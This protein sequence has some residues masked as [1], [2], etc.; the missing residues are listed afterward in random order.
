MGIWVLQLLDRL[1]EGTMRALGAASNLAFLIGPMLLAVMLVRRW[2]GDPQQFRVEAGAVVLACLTSITAAAFLG[3]A[4]IVGAFQGIGRQG[5]GGLGVVTDGVVAATQPLVAAVLSAA[6]CLVVFTIVMFIRVGR[7][8][9]TGMAAKPSRKWAAGWSLLLAGALVAVDQ[10]L[11]LHHE[12]TALL[13]DLLGPTRSGRTGAYLAARSEEVFP[14]LLAYGFV[15]SV[16]I[17]A[18]TIGMWRASR[19][20]GAHPML[21]W[22]SSAA[23]VVVLIGGA[24]H[25]QI[26]RRDL[27]TYR[28][29]IAMLQAQPPAR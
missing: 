17:V 7:R 5:H 27:R 25:A 21:T 3:T 28:D 14:P 12:M 19:T 26:V 11:R 1:P 15:L 18:L 16:V 24:W 6:I 2:R 8:G 9:L 22:V 20:R 10:L 4:G 13:V 23:L 29:N